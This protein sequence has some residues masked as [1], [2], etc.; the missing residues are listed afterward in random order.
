MHRDELDD[1]GSSAHFPSTFH[2]DCEL[3]LLDDAAPTTSATTTTNNAVA[4]APSARQLQQSDASARKLS[5]APPP[6]LSPSDTA[7]I[8]GWLYKQGGFVKNWKKRWFVAREGKIMYFHGASDPTP[9]GTVDLRGVTVAVSDANE[10]NARNQCLYYFKIVPRQRDQRTYY[11]GADTEPEMIRWIRALGK[12]SAFGIT[13]YAG[14]NSG[15]SS[16]GSRAEWNS[17]VIDDRG[18][19]RGNDVRYSDSRVAYG[20]SERIPISLLSLKSPP[21]Y[22]DRDASVSATALRS[23]RKQHNATELTYNIQPSDLTRGESF[24][25]R[26][27]SFRERQSS[28]RGYGSVSLTET[29]DDDVQPYLDAK[30]QPEYV[31]SKPIAF[32]APMFSDNERATILQ[33]VESFGGGIYVY[34]ADELT[35]IARLQT[36]LRATPTHDS[37]STLYAL[38]QRLIAQKHAAEAEEMLVDVVIKFFPRLVDAMDYDPLAF[39][40]MVADAS[41]TQHSSAVGQSGGVFF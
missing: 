17:S 8:T 29:D 28:A 22:D 25:E 27:P 9:L 32:A 38:L 26:Q 5:V 23:A 16:R 10:L 35:E 13:G 6:P 39:T 34:S 31:P 14:G 11:F 2:V 41:T 18:S 19:S 1:V 12:Q 40:Q 24:S 4:N 37:R 3:E 15:S 30:L 20:Q 21:T 33:E 36:H 7:P